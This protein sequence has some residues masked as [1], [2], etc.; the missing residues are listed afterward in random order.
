MKV[1]KINLIP[2]WTILSIMLIMT[3]V[4]SNLHWS[5]QDSWKNIIG[6]D[7]KGYYAYLPAVFVYQDLNFGFF[8]EIE[9][10][11]YFHESGIYDYRSFY[12]GHLINKYYAGTAVAQLP[13]FLIGHALSEPLGFPADGYSKPYIIAIT[14]GSLFYLFIGLLFLSKLLTLFDIQKWNNALVLIAFTFGSNLFCY[15]IIDVG[16]SHVYSFTFITIFLYYVK[17]YF[18]NFNPKN[19]LIIAACLGLIV[20]IRPVNGLI[21]LS[22]PFLAGSSEKLKQGLKSLIQEHRTTTFTSV[23]I[24]FIIASIQLI[25]YKISTGNFL[26]YSYG[27]EGFNFLSPHIFDILF[28]Y[29]KGLFLYTPIFLLSLLGLYF[30]RRTNKFEVKALSAFLLILVYILSSWWNWWYGGSFSSRVFVE[31]IPFF[32]ILLGI[33]LTHTK[34]LFYRASL[35]SI[36][37]III[38]ICQIQMYQYRYYFIHYEEMN[39]EKYWDVFLRIDLL[40]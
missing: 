23:I 30:M 27:Q 4:S 39:M 9:K 26:A 35:L 14:I 24:G 19:I 40:T 22:I 37:I 17:R 1:S 6:A 28:S 18:L 25:I 36:T 31:Y 8:D 13:F 2:N 29:R 16:Y 12:K 34:Q 33:T 20:L 38:V 15:T 3:L 5:K 7:A 11:K 21:I 10:E 32:A